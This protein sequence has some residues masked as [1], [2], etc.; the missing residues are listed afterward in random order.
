LV[1]AG[2]GDPGLITVRGLECLRMAEVIVTDRLA[3]PALLSHARPDARVVDAGKESGHHRLRQEEINAL[4]VKEALAGHTV[5]RLKGGDPF[6][7]GRGGEEALALV[8]HEIPFEIVPG[9]TSAVAAAAYA[10]IPVTERGMASALGI[11]TGHED[12]AKTE[13]SLNWQGLAQG[14]DTL[15]FLMGVSNLPAIV[16]R[17]LAHGRMPETP[18][19]VI[20]R[21]TTPHQR[22]VVGTLGDI[23]RKVEEAGLAAPAV[24][25]VGE[26]VGL[27]DRLRWF[28]TRPLFGRRIL[29]T[30]TRPQTSRLRDLLAAQ[31]AEVIE[32]P[33]IAVEPMANGL[34]RAAA[35]LVDPG[36]AWVVFTSVPG[37]DFFFDQLATAGLDARAFG[38]AR[39]A[40]VGDA[41]VA[42]LQRHG[43]RAD[44]VPSRFTSEALGDELPGDLQ[45]VRILLPRA[46]LGSPL[47]RERLEARGAQLEDVAIYRT[48]PDATGGELVQATIA[49]GGVDVITFASSSAVEHFVAL[50]L[51]ASVGRARIA[52]IGPVTAE[53]AREHGLPVA[54]VADPSTIEGLMAALLLDA[55][56]ENPHG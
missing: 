37:V 45:G 26:V 52:C 40:A 18:V 51:A 1:G 39:V 13:S 28:D 29:V 5:C 24:I 35:L 55:E 42:A 34:T 30:R 19:A 48:I 31:G 47:L 11:V 41:T 49:A 38:R 7:F 50:G 14:L 6:V 54:I 22:T 20:H 56:K 16:E 32:A 53:T 3:N 23:V 27:R 21:G 36:C 17:L 2:P 9:V 10:G 44:F 43:L 33:L 4:L 8:A 25:V 15:V 12:P 46:E